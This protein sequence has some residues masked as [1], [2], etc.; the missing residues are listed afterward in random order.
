MVTHPWGVGG[1]CGGA[2]KGDGR[3]GKGGNCLT[4]GAEV[5][6]METVATEELS[7]IGV[8]PTTGLNLEGEVS[9]VTKLSTRSLSGSA[10]RLL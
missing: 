9:G 8:E 1:S 3:G 6:G 5:V 7:E 4:L 10:L 2:S